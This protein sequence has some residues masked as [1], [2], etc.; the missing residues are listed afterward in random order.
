MPIEDVPHVINVLHIRLYKRSA[1]GKKT[2]F[3]VGLQYNLYQ[4]S[5]TKVAVFIILL[6]IFRLVQE[7][8]DWTVGTPGAL[9]ETLL[10]AQ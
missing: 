2:D 5:R 6:V 8:Q 7:T 10:I 9:Y 3:V 4:K 1:E